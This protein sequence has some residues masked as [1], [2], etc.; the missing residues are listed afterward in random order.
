MG[1]ED[2]LTKVSGVW[3]RAG[4]GASVREE[5]EEAMQEGREKG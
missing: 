4:V 1:T 3:L 2:Y 5:K